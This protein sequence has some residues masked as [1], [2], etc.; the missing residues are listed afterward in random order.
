VSHKESPSYKI[1]GACHRKKYVNQKKNFATYCVC[2]LLTFQKLPKNSEKFKY[3][4]E[5]NT[6]LKNNLR[7][8]VIFG[9]KT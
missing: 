4:N 1:P 8:C 2:G 6:T 3:T 5:Q 9:T 7:I